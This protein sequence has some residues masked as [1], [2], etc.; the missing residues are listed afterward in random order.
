[1]IKNNLNIK[2][3]SKFA[4]SKQSK[5]VK[6]ENNLNLLNKNNEIDFQVV[7]TDLHDFQHFIETLV[8][9]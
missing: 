4:K 2:N 7:H 3:S 9:F 6:Q 8:Y 1:M 5:F